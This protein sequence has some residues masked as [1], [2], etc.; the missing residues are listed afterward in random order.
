MTDN[1]FHATDLLWAITRYIISKSSAEGQSDTIVI[2]RK[3]YAGDR[4]NI[5]NLPYTSFDFG[6]GVCDDTKGELASIKSK[7]TI[8]GLEIGH[9]GTKRSFLYF[10]TNYMAE[11]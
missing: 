11:E 7:Q 5:F 10:C 1:V 6:F 2:A 4:I 9:L 3:N 8:Y